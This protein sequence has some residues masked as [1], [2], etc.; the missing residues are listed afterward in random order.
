MKKLIYI[1][2]SFSFLSILTSCEDYNEKNF[3]GYAQMERPTNLASYSYTLTGTDFE[4]I[5]NAIKKDVE[6]LISAEQ[7]KLTAKLSEYK[8]ATN[9]TDSAR[10]KAEYDALKP[11]VDANVAT[12]KLDP[13]YVT[14]MFLKTNKFFNDTYTASDYAPELLNSKYKFADVGSSV[15]LTFKVRNDIDTLTVAAT[16]KYTM[17]VDDYNAL[18][19][20]VNQPGQ[21]DNF[22]SLID[23]DVFIPRFLSVK[24]PLAQKDDIKMIKYL[25]YVSAPA[26][27]TYTLFKYNGATWQAFSKT[28]QFVF[29]DSNKWIFDPTITITPVAD[30]FKL[31]LMP[32]LYE[33]NGKTLPELEG[34]NEWTATD[35]VRF[36]INPLYPPASAT[37]FT[38]VRNEFFF[39]TSWYYVNI[40]IRITS[41][42]YASD[43][44]LQNYFASVDVDAALDADGKKSAKTAFLEKRVKQGLAIMLSLKYPELEPKVKGVDQHV[45]VNVQVYDGARWY[46]T[47]DYKCVEKGKFD[48]VGRTK[49]K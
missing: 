3:E 1:F 4:T 31:L 2:L 12:S 10:I 49:W 20:A 45:K 28:E 9:A 25:F 38:N 40:D 23:P 5:G 6:A 13:N 44:Q 27:M 14:G 22:S 29:A 24:Y 37:D 30:D 26:T 32:F 18:G 17:V 42:T 7:A 16:N 47:Y 48:Y 39:G 46:W 21:F 11:I 19:E 41:R 15:Q 36:V 34:I 33:Y 43:S 8:T 35:T